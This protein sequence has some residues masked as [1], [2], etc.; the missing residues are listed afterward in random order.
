MPLGVHRL[1]KAKTSHLFLENRIVDLVLVIS[2]CPDR[3]RLAEGENER[4]AV[5]EILDFLAP[6]MPVARSR[7]IESNVHAPANDRRPLGLESRLFR[8]QLLSSI[9]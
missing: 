2:H 8:L 5:E 4:D 9:G 6:A 1:L 3:E 7:G